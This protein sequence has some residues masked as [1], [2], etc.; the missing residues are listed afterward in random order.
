MWCQLMPPG[1]KGLRRALDDSRGSLIAGVSLLGVEPHSLQFY[2]GI[3]SVVVEV[4]VL[5]T[6][7]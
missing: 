2:I 5:E 7:L 4:M 1:P 3:T 6:V